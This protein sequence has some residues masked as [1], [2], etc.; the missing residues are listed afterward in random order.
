MRYKS[1]ITQLTK[2]HWLDAGYDI[3]SNE[4]VIIKPKG[5]AI[6][7]TNLYVEI[8][9]GYAGL[10]WSRS[11]LSC[12]YEIETGAGCIDSSYRGEVKVHLYNHSD[13]P[14]TVNKGDKITQLGGFMTYIGIVVT[15]ILLIRIVEASSMTSSFQRAQEYRQKQD[16]INEEMVE[17]HRLILKALED[18][19]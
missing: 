17:L 6:I 10:L 16:E 14:Y 2:T 8:P 18:K 5:S 19:K 11:G 13:L 12:N 15:L 7:G 1:E 4:T 9:D 3:Y